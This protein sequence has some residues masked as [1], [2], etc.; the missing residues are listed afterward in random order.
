MNIIGKAI[1]GN[2]R[3]HD[4]RTLAETKAEYNNPLTDWVVLLTAEVKARQSLGIVVQGKVCVRCKVVQQPKERNWRHRGAHG[5][6]LCPKCGEE[7][8]A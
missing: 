5:G 8:G 2:G 6:W 3:L 4:G 1:A 7:V